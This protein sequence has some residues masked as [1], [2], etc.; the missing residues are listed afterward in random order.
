VLYEL[1]DGQGPASIK[2]QTIRNLVASLAAIAGV[3]SIAGKT[4]G[5]WS[6][7]P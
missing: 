3:T 7:I 2:L 4:G 6:S 1:R 5:R